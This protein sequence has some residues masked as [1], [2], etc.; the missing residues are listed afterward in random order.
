MLTTGAAGMRS[1]AL[2]LAEAVGLPIV[3]KRIVVGAPWRWLPGGFLPMPLAALGR[4]SDPIA[5]PWPALVIGCGRRSIGPAL[6]IK[7]LS[8]G[9]TLAAYVQNPERAREKFD[10]VAAMPHDSVAGPNVVALDTALH[11]VTEAKLEISR[12]AWLDELK[13]DRKALL[14]ALIGGDNGGYR[15]T[16]EIV[17]RLIRLLEDAHQQH[18]FRAA[19]TPSRRT[20]KE[21]RRALAAALGGKDWTSLWNGE[22]DNPYLGILGLS[23]RLIVTGE[24]ISMISEALAA[25]RPVHVLP[26]EGQGRRHDA[27]LTRM[28]DSGFVS[29]IEGESLDWKF[30]GTAPIN[31][32]IEP[33]RRIRAMLAQRNG[34]P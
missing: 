21:A 18:G 29:L 8:R 27:F 19:V 1:Q 25:G 23:D 28:A 4:G 5:P 6:A 34:G 10:L 17:A 33:A 2:G 26:L 24:S 7:R 11:G 32:A 15:L 14:G 31:S 16:E 9:R 13:P 22:G 20:G 12:A 3:E 30:A